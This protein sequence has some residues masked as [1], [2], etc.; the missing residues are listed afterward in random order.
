MKAQYADLQQLYIE[1]KSKT[2]ELNEEI[3]ALSKKMKKISFQV[4]KT[5][6][7]ERD[8]QKLLENYQTSEGIRL[9]QKDLIT[10]LKNELAQLKRSSAKARAQHHETKKRSLSKK[11]N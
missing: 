3:S 8:Y 11:A 7:L 5:L 10:E 9:Q 2:L 1:E 4:D 6:E